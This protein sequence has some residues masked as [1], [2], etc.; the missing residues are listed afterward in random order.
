MQNLEFSGLLAVAAVAFLIP[1]VLGLVP[2]LRMPASVLEVVAGIALGPAVLGWVKADGS[3]MIF[4]LLGLAFLLFFAGLEIDFEHLRGRP[5]LLT[6]LGFVVSL[7]LAF[8][9]AL[10][11]GRSV[12]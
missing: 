11:S 9:V 1:F 8:A 3:V 5:L 4:G 7:G 6:L 10:V 12:G 2:R